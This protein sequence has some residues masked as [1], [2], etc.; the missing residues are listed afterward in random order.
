MAV[1]SVNNNSGIYAGTGLALG[2]LGGGF[3]GHS[4]KPYLEKDAP[5]DS[6]VKTV[7]ENFV[8]NTIEEYNKY[9]DISTYDYPIDLIYSKLEITYENN[10]LTKLVF[11]DK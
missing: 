1:E 9:S 5:K 10:K 6:F 2:A 7:Q 3:Y 4:T 11:R 8:N